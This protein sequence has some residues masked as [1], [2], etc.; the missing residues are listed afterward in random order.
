MSLYVPSCPSTQNHLKAAQGHENT[1]WWDNLQRQVLGDRHM[2]CETEIWPV[3]QRHVL[4]GIHTSCETDTCPARQRHVLRDRHMSCETYTCPVRQRQSSDDR[5]FKAD[6]LNKDND[7]QRRS[8]IWSDRDTPARFWP[9]KECSQNFILRTIRTGS[10]EF[11]SLMSEIMK[12]WLKS[13][14]EWVSLHDTSLHSSWNN[15]S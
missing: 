6:V 4:W 10:R 13:C 15:E 1:Q 8:S 7:P 9:R 14:M 3:R 2:S 11:Y 12:L 5:P